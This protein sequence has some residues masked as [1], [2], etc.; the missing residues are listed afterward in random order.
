VTETKNVSSKRLPWFETESLLTFPSERDKSSNEKADPAR[1][2]C[3]SSMFAQTCRLPT[4]VPTR[5]PSKSLQRCAAS[6]VD[7][8]AA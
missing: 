3:H 7:P 5:A 6:L 8:C 2:E 1:S 4:A